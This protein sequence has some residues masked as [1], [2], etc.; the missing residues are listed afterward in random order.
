MMNWLEGLKAGLGGGGDE[1]WYHFSYEGE[2][3]G[4]CFKAVIS[5]NGEKGIVKKIEEF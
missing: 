2:M 1:W 4:I 5:G 3:K